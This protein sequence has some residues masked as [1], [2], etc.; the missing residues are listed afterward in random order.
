MNEE[1]TMSRRGL[2][3]VSRKTRTPGGRKK[4][5]WSKINNPV[6][7][8]SFFWVRTKYL[9][10]YQILIFSDLKP[11]DDFFFENIFLTF[12]DCKGSKNVLVLPKDF[13]TE[14]LILD[15]CVKAGF[16]VYLAYQLLDNV[17]FDQMVGEAINKHVDITLKKKQLLTSLS[18]SKFLPQ[19]DERIRKQIKEIRE[20]MT[21]QQLDVVLKIKEIKIGQN[22]DMLV[23]LLALLNSKG[24]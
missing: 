21:S 2:D 16:C 15:Y 8:L 19:I 17:S 22:M 10:Q 6:R 11:E 9:F 7:K 13:R 12:T 4:A 23:Q 24:R 5:Q 3:P 20:F 18:G 14:F 1:A